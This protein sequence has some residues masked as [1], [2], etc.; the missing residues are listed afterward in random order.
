M[1]K[2]ISKRYYDSIQNL[3]LKLSESLTLKPDWRLIVGLGNESIYETSM[4]LHHI[5]GFPYIPGSAIKGVTRNYYIN[6]IYDRIR[7]NNVEQ[8]NIIEKIL[9]ISNLR[10]III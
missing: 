9:K 6:D 3:N 5:Y 4:T 2:A 10:K 7:L 1:I 8:I